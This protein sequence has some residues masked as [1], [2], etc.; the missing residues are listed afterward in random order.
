MTRVVAKKI[1]PIKVAQPEDIAEILGKLQTVLAG[2]P[3]PWLRK[4][5]MKGAERE[6]NFEDEEVGHG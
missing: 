2:T 3:P 5:L 4:A 1:H 6:L